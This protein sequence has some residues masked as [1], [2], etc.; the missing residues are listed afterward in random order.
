MYKILEYVGLEVGYKR[1]KGGK[2]DVPLSMFCGKDEGEVEDITTTL[3]NTVPFLYLF[4]DKQR[5]FEMGHVA[6]DRHVVDLQANKI[7]VAVMN[8]IACFFVLN[9]GFGRGFFQQVFFQLPT[10]REGKATTLLK[11]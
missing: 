2:S 11:C 10:Q 1:G 9:I 3:P 5:K 6:G 4:F 8:Y 7:V